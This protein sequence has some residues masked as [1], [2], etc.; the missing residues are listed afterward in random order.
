MKRRSVAWIV[1]S[2]AG[3][4]ALGMGVP[5]AHAQ[6]HAVAVRVAPAA[7]ATSTTRAGYVLA[8]PPASAS[9]GDR[10]KV[11]TLTCPSTG[12]SGIALGAF[13]FTSSGLSGA[14]VTAGCSS[15]TAVYAGVL[16]VNGRTFAATF[17][18]AAGDAMKAL[19]SESTTATNTG[20]VDITQSLGDDDGSTAG[21][22]N[23]AILVGMHSLVSS[24]NTKLPLPPFGTERFT[25]GTID[26]G[27]VKAS[28]AVAEDM[29][30]HTRVLQIHTGALNSTG[31]AWSEIFRRS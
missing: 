15:G 3:V 21:A 25:A 26:G 16:T 10:F 17:T 7:N 2:G 9:A 5:Q 29:T 24:S 19:V 22:T 1:A 27:T 31:T 6:S 23:S 28:G 20:L 12:T 8:H 14:E 4:V 30:R 13:I 18:P 11:P